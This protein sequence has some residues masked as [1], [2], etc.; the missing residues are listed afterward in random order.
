MR[1]SFFILR[2]PQALII[3]L[4]NDSSHEI[5]KRQ[6]KKNAAFADA[7]GVSRDQVP[8]LIISHLHASIYIYM[9]A[10]IIDGLN[11]F[12]C[13]QRPG[14]AFDED[15]QEERKQERMDRQQKEWEARQAGREEVSA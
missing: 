4:H 6:E 2:L 5:A 1:L 11:I 12:G 13:S 7:L 3:T 8:V 14:E 10:V 15:L 9:V